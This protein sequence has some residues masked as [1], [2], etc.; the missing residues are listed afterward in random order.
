QN[1]AQYWLL[2]QQAGAAR[3]AGNRAEARRLLERAVRL[4]ANEVT[5][6][7]ALA[8]LLAEDRQYAQAE[9][10]Y[11]R[12]LPRQPD[13]PD[14]TR[15]LVSVLA[16]QNKST[17]ALALVERM[18]PA[19]REKVGSVGKL[20]AD[21]ARAQ[22]RQALQAGD[23]ASARRALEDAMAADPTNPWVRLDV[24]R[25]YVAMGNPEQ[26]RIVMDN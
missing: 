10:A 9:A 7:V 17:E 19:Q 21:Q 4:D 2:V 16:A 25:N 26:A 15:G 13:N 12:V 18:T 6:Q 20:R 14:A 11:R 22:A 3:D 8:D 1:S 5:G 23:T 24:A